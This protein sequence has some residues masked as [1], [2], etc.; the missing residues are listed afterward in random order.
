MCLRKDG[1][2]SVKRITWVESHDFADILPYPTYRI[3]SDRGLDH[4]GQPH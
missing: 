4:R 2:K 1:I 3:G